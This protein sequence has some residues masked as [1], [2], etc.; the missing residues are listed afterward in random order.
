MLNN[1]GVG[2]TAAAGLFAVIALAFAVS[3]DSNR[4]WDAA[5][6]EFMSASVSNPDQ[7][8]SQGKTS[9]A[10]SKRK[11]PTHHCR[12][13]GQSAGGPGGPATQRMDQG[14]WLPMVG[15]QKA[16]QSPTVLQQGACRYIRARNLSGCFPAIGGSAEHSCGEFA[17]GQGFPQTS[18]T[19][20]NISK[21]RK[22]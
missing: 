1:Y 4:S 5:G 7:S 18:C 11:L 3:V 17:A 15:S 22:N 20:T 12:N 19:P 2:T 21:W 14:M 10:Q 16:F 8:N 6:N 9:C 13:R